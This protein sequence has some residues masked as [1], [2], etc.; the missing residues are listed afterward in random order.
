MG[1]IWDYRGFIWGL[2]SNSDYRAWSVL[3]PCP[4]STTPNPRVVEC[5]PNTDSPGI[6]LLTCGS[7]RMT[8]MP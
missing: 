4:T 8:I 3:I 1:I 5:L 7:V 2:Y 6:A